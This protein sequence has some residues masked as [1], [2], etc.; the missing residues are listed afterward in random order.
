MINGSLKDGIWVEDNLGEKLG[1]QNGDK[2]VSVDNREISNFNRVNI[3]F[4]NGSTFKIERNGQIIDKEI[5]ENFINELLKRGKRSGPFVSWRVPFM[6]GDEFS[7]ILLTRVA[8]SNI[9]TWWFLNG[10]ETPYYDIA[11]KEL[12]KFKNVCFS[13]HQKR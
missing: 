7:K 9:R 4:I 1:L 13:D 10:L 2:I 6:I 8:V 5:P 3:E 12:L 11:Q